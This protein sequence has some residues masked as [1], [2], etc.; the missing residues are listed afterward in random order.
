[1]AGLASAG[2]GIFLGSCGLRRGAGTAS[3]ERETTPATPS[4]A[5]SDQR[6]LGKSLTV[7]AWGGEVQDVLRAVIWQPFS[8]L[9]GC[10]IKELPADL[11]RLR[12]TVEAGEPYTDLILVSGVWAETE[13]GR[14][15]TEPFAAELSRARQFTPYPAT[16]RQVPAYTYA[17]VSCFSRDLETRNSQPRDWSQ[18]WDTETLPGSR[19]LPASPLGTLEFALLADGVDRSSLYPLD[20]DRALDSLSAVKDAVADRWWTDGFEPIGWIAAGAVTLSSAWHYRA[21]AGQRDGRA[22]GFSWD[23]GIL[24]ADVW[25]VPRG[26]ANNVIAA[27][28]VEFATS[29]EV[30]AKLGA[31]LPLGPVVFD[32]FESIADRDAIW[33]PT[34]PPNL[35]RLILYDPS[36]WG[37]HLADATERFE[38]WRGMISC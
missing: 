34:H 31:A 20:I 19:S 8:A 6:W 26:S 14:R 11:T 7:S 17:L 35:K 38:C 37:D 5:R 15:L 22:V 10:A 21:I 33:L 13:L 16:E 12:A 2:S 28:L 3:Q 4:A 18:W 36:W 1:M 32:A 9:T 27:D 25:T 23:S 24:Y 30:Q 29:P